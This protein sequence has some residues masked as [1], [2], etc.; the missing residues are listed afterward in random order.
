M[1]K[2]PQKVQNSSLGGIFTYQHSFGKG[3][4]SA[5]EE[6]T[7]QTF[8]HYNIGNGSFLQSEGVTQINSGKGV[9]VVPVGLGIG[10]AWK[11]TSGAT[12]SGF[13]EPQYSVWRRGAARRHGSSLAVSVSRFLLSLSSG[14]SDQYLRFS[15]KT[16]RLSSVPPVSATMQSPILC[17]SLYRYDFE[18]SSISTTTIVISSSWPFVDPV[19]DQARTFFSNRSTNCSAPRLCFS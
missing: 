17:R 13:L 5:T 19:R 15:M 16:A 10:K 11:Y 1:R 8:I 14:T 3:P 12:L 6:A 2:R 18:L 4:G 9:R 7:F